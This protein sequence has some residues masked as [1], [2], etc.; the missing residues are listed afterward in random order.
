MRKSPSFPES[1]SN[2]PPIRG[3]IIV[4]VSRLILLR[5]FAVLGV[6][7]V[8]GVTMDLPVTV[9]Y[10]AQWIL[11]L[12]LLGFNVIYHLYTHY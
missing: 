2:Q 5:Y 1:P 10:H 9:P 4:R 11:V 7:V 12:I 3:E 6:C 8:L